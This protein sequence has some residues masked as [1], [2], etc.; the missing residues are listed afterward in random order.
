MASNVS[1]DQQTAS[2]EQRII[3]L[4]NTFSKDDAVYCVLLDAGFAGS[5][6]SPMKETERS[7]VARSARELD[8]DFESDMDHLNSL[9]KGGTDC[10]K[11]AASYL[12]KEERELVFGHV[13]DVMMH[14]GPLTDAESGVGAV[15]KEEFGIDK[16]SLEQ[17]FD[18]AWSRNREIQEAE[19]EVLFR[20]EAEMITVTPEHFVYIDNTIPIAEIR[21]ASYVK[22]TDFG[23]YARVAFFTIVGLLLVSMFN[24]WSI[25][26]L[27]L[28][29][30]P[31]I[32]FSSKKKYWILITQEHGS[33]YV[34][35]ADST[36]KFT[37]EIAKDASDAV[38]LAAQ[39]YREAT[40]PHQ[41]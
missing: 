19:S 6:G 26:G 15:I 21:R 36:T 20:D 41:R 3:A 18:N 22:S 13:L 10:I 35:E 4:Q 12:T 27:L 11:L 23:D 17:I 1:K 32:F 24:I 38:N 7:I 28:L 9:L 2:E 8:L 39:N 34:G 5:G 31:I 33:I 25:L 30:Y 37:K 29:I 40:E 16:E 14:D